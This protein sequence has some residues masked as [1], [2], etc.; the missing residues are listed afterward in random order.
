[1]QTEGKTKS[2]L[3]SLIT[4]KGKRVQTTSI[5]FHLSPKTKF[6]RKD[7]EQGNQENCD[8]LSVNNRY[9]TISSPS[10][11]LLQVIPPM[12]LIL[13]YSFERNVQLEILFMNSYLIQSKPGKLLLYQFLI[14]QKNSDSYLHP[15][16]TGITLGKLALSSS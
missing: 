1:M 13:L 6:V 16:S 7:Y 2:L 9:C 11:A 4:Q 15:I 12:R 14:M 3:G 8:P 5:L 10:I